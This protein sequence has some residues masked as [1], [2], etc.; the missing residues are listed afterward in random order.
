MLN[1]AIQY[2]RIVRNITIEDSLNHLALTTSEWEILENLKDVLKVHTIGIFIIFL[3]HHTFVGFQRH[4]PFCPS[5]RRQPCH[6]HFSDG[7]AG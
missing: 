3:P 2:K 4:H 1:T 7:Q 5:G 6:H